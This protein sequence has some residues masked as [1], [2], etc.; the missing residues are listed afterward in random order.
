MCKPSMLN[1]NC[2]TQRCVIC[3]QYQ[4]KFF[5]CFNY[6]INKNI[7]LFSTNIPY[8]EHHLHEL[9]MSDI[10][11]S[12]DTSTCTYLYF[13]V[14]YVRLCIV[15]VVVDACIIIIQELYVIPHTEPSS[16]TIICI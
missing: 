12:T 5:T 9:I 16:V 8:M 11:D 14:N 3:V 13:M 15:C 4:G 1:D 7:N 6:I 2:G 10:C